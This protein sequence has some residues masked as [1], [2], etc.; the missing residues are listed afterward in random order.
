[1]ERE[2]IG[3]K[4]KGYLGSQ[5]E[6]VMLGEERRETEVWEGGMGIAGVISQSC[7]GKMRIKLPIIGLKIALRFESLDGELVSVCV[8]VCVYP[9]TEN[10]KTLSS[11]CYY[12]SHPSTHPLIRPSPSRSS[13][14]L[15]I[16]N[17]KKKNTCLSLPLKPTLRFSE[18]L[19][20]SVVLAIRGGKE[21]QRETT[22][23]GWWEEWKRKAKKRRKENG[24]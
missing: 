20:S 13:L 23:D 1:M 2:R 8:S 9:E 18:A 10:P 12:G 7:R 21:T 4:V 22:G 3:D 24:G 17:S 14:C 19:L 6:V 16:S 11:L 5:K 15:C